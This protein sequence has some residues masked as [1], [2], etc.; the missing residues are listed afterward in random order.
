[1][2]GDRKPIPYLQTG[3]SQIQAQVS[4]D[5]RWLAYA[6]DESG[7]WEVYLQSFPMPGM[8]R[9][10]SVGGGGEPHWS[11]D[12]KHLF[13]M[14]ADKTLIS[15]DVRLGDTSATLG[16]SK[17]LFAVPVV[18]DTTSFRSRYVV[19]LK[20]HRFLFNAIDESQQDPITV[21]ANWEGLVK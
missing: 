13:Y 12:G 11:D 21:V 10:V 9:I 17:V 19:H 20:D 1:M 6:S 14:R 7:Q 2:F 3:S 8:K 16:P 4:P 18:G 5:G 15:V